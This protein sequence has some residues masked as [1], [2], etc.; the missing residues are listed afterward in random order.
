VKQICDQ[1][2]TDLPRL[3]VF[4]V[5]RHH[6]VRPRPSVAPSCRLWCGSGSGFSLSCGSGSGLSLS[7]GSGSGFSKWC[8]SMR[9]GLATLLSIWQIYMRLYCTVLLIS[10]WSMGTLLNCSIHYSSVR[11]MNFGHFLSEWINT[12]WAFY[13]KYIF[14]AVFY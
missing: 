11:M 14:S 10:V 2:N 4:G 7:C 3:H 1:W 12:L 13:D 8:G 5:P 6:C 9:T